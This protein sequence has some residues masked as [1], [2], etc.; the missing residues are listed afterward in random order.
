MATIYVIKTGRTVWED[1]DRIDSSTG[2]PLTDSGVEK[3]RQIAAELS[4]FKIR[5]VYT[6][7]SDAESQTAKILGK[8][9][10][11]KV[12]VRKDLREFDYGLWQG[13]T[14]QELRRRQPKVYKQWTDAPASVRA[15]G[16]ETLEELQDRIRKAIHEVVRKQSK[17]DGHALIVLRPIALGV[18]RCLIQE[19]D[20]EDLWSHVDPEF[21]WGAYEADPQQL[22]D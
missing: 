15:P 7:A 12:H 5:H 10:K 19:H 20:V 6:G 13:L 16:G 14:H 9:L 18:L 8:L 22:E 21:T 4:D 17:K 2:S 3:V 11:A 1:Q